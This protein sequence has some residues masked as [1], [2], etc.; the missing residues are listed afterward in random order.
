MAV[1]A[2][3]MNE[4]VREHQDS[5]EGAVVSLRSRRRRG[6]RRALP[7]LRDCREASGLTLTDIALATGR[8][9]ATVSAIELQKNDASP[10]DQVAWAQLLEANVD[11]LF[12]PPPTAIWSASVPRGACGTA[13]CDDADCDIPFGLCHCGCANRAPIAK[14]NDRRR[15]VVRGEPQLYAQGHGRQAKTLMA[16]G[17]GEPL[18]DAIRAS[19]LTQRQL[20]L[21]SGLSE[22]VVNGLLAY[23]SY[24]V[25]SD[26]CEAIVAAIRGAL[27]RAGQPT[28][29]VTLEQLFTRDRPATEPPAG[30]RKHRKTR[31]RPPLPRNERYDGRHF[32]E[33]PPNKG[34]TL[35]LETRG[36]IGAAHR[37]QPD[38][39]A[40]ERLLREWAVGGPTIG[41]LLDNDQ[42]N[43][44]ER[45]IKP[46][47]RQIYGRTWG[48]RKGAALGG[49]SKGREH[50]LQAVD[51]AE[52]FV[53]D[54]PRAR[55]RDVMDRL[56]VDFTRLAFPGD[57]DRA[58]RE[59]ASVI[60]DESGAR[61]GA[62]D[63]H[64]RPARAR[65]DRY[66]A[67]GFRELGG[68]PET[69]WHLFG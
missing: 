23:D 22:G 54:T 19:G 53:A 11:D 66:L 26:R 3:V 36:K 35:S 59:A 13:G 39:V 21:A 37:G 40:R 50:G 69:L 31:R 9:K 48:G 12:A 25:S 34:K 4:N 58:A 30:Q 18:A 16:A 10:E 61:R 55:R 28:A 6:Y 15:R 62:R 29:E 5:A 38:P 65:V 57:P 27:E 43:R 46:E 52:R 8:T 20:S 14:Q 7:A 45:P 60:F 56:I 42:N 51:F 64:Y 17:D 67:R 33:D 41:A 32:K 63:P 2:A 44:P 1:A 47:T 24:R 49:A 68:V